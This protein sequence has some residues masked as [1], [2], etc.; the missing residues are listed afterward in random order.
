[1]GKKKVEPQQIDEGVKDAILGALMS[2]SFMT[3]AKAGPIAANLASNIDS[4][5]VSSVVKSIKSA[6]STTELSSIIK[7]YS[8]DTEDI[9][10]DANIPK[11]SGYKPLTVQQR[12]DWNKYLFYLGDK[13]GDPDL[14][15]GVPTKGRQLLK[16]YL[17]KNPNSSL[18][19]FEN[20]DDLV[21][22][23]QYEMQLIRRGTEFPGITPFELKV[24]QTL[25][26]KDRK[27][28]MMVNR[29]KTD[30]NPGQF[31]TQEFYP[32]FSGSADYGNRMNTI[33]NTLVHIYKIKTIDGKDITKYAKE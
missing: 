13:R 32:S 17:E 14:D 27:P 30:G 3:A 5:K 21:K 31:T 29:S 8:P 4:S 10:V 19:D 9:K 16:D 12:E 22:S 24:I 1:M 18:N 28:W 6:D 20:Q 11:P 25:M 33:Y 15:R 7:S 23:I 26:L 2:L